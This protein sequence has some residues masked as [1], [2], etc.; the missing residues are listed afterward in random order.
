MTMQ[1]EPIPL[2]RRAYEEMQQEL[3]RLRTDG[4][5][6]AA[7]EIRAARESELDQDEDVVPALEAANDQRAFL[8]G[9]IMELEATLARATIIDEEA[10][11]AS[12]TVQIGSRV[13][14]EHNGEEKTYQIVSPA[15]ADASAG[16]ISNES[17][18][19]A[20]LLGK[21]AGETVEFDAPAGPQRLR[22]TSLG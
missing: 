5:R 8:E 11:R 10:V 13:V 21:R 2:T 17:P 20:A 1:Y 4:R 3:E 12:D 15:E 6:E 9:R 18:I 16:K 19:G 22:I 7:E 14:V